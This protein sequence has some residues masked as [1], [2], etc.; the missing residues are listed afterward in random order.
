MDSMLKDVV[1]RGTATKARAMKRGDI[2]GKT[3]TTN[4]PRD[5]WFSGYNPDLVTTT[6][7]GFD[8]N[9]K[10]GRREFGGP[11]DMDRLYE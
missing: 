9:R 8:D 3:G 5:A 1:K 7:L 6:W 2:A 10:L 11:A 4:G